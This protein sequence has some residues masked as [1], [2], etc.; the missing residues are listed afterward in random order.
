[1]TPKERRLASI[2]RRALRDLRGADA[3]A[4]KQAQIDLRTSRA[5]LTG[6]WG[7]LAKWKKENPDAE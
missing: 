2:H 6:F 3:E 7:R 4:K 5:G 1:M